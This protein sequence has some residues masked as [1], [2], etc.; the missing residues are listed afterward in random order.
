M[1]RAV[2]AR[3]WAD[4]GI[5]CIDQLGFSSFVVLAVFRLH[6]DRVVPSAPSR[7]D[8]QPASLPGRSSSTSFSRFSLRIFSPLHALT[9]LIVFSQLFL[10]SSSVP[11]SAYPSRTTSKFRE[12]F[13]YTFTVANECSEL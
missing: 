6:V 2:G 7:S 1:H 3:S 9:L 5:H 11:T 10:L 13:R 12:M 4:L 8:R